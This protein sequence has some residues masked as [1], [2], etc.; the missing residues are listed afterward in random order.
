[1]MECSSQAAPLHRITYADLP[2]PSRLL[3]P[4]LCSP[5]RSGLPLPGMASL[6]MVMTMIEIVDWVLLA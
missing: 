4:P 6:L 3:S 2:F 5:L 1:M